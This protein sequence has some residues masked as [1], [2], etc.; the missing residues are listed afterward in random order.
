MGSTT[1]EM[2]AWVDMDLPVSE[3]LGQMD[4]TALV[5]PVSVDSGDT[6]VLDQTR[7]EAAVSDSEQVV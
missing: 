6:T 3:V 2:Q 5:H 7:M 4:S 1:L